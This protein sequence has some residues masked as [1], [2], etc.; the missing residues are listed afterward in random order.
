MYE[1]TGMV[2]SP[3]QTIPGQT[4]GDVWNGKIATM[5]SGSDFTAFQDFAGVPSIDMGFSAAPGSPVYQ[6][7]SNYDDYY[8]MEKYGDPGWHY[9]VAAAKSK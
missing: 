1:I 2:Q 8:W 9:H 6:Y 3:N 5:G 7:H 4:V